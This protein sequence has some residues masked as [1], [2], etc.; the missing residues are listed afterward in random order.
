MAEDNSETIENP[1][2]DFLSAKWDYAAMLALLV[3]VCFMIVGVLGWTQERGNA[4]RAQGIIQSL[5]TTYGADDV[6]LPKNPELTPT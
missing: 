4:D 3:V 1:D 5:A 6:K 2:D